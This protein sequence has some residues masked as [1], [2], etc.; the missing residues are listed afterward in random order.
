[1][2]TTN[3]NKNMNGSE[4]DNFVNE[5]VK[6]YDITNNC[7]LNTGNSF[8]HFT[9]SEKAVNDIESLREFEKDHNHESFFFHL[10]ETL[11]NFMDGE[12][13]VF[14]REFV[15]IFNELSFYSGILTNIVKTMQ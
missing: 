2:K 9:L 10:L 8:R 5:I 7:V 1:M 12:G 13:A 14:D 4:Y 15:K 6:T 11:S 3:G